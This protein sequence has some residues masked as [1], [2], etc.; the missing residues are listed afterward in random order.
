MNDD[1]DSESDDSVRRINLTDAD[2]QVEYKS[3]FRKTQLA[4]ARYARD[5]AGEIEVV[6]GEGA[7][8]TPSKKVLEHQYSVTSALINSLSFLEG[9]KYW[10]LYCVDDGRWDFENRR[11]IVETGWKGTEDAL[12]RILDI[13]D[14]NKE[15]MQAS[16][17]YNEVRTIRRFRNELLH[18]ETPSVKLGNESV[19]YELDNELRD[20]GVDENPVGDSYMYP[21]RWLSYDLANRSVDMCVGL[22][23]IFAIGMDMSEELA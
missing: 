8:M 2:F 22:W 12:V 21:Y 5:I 18:F 15:L 14:G 17:A 1:I 16:R 4:F 10:F 20:M 7:K 13:C 23:R 11:D 19:E 9:Q 3:G 6:F